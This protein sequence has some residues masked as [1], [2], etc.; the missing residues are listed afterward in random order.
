MAD[1]T[2]QQT[3]IGQEELGAGPADQAPEA[4]N[5][6]NTVTPKTIRDARSYPYRLV[7]QIRKQAGQ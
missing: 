2:D 1:I 3:H 4:K 7:A 6:L 5:L